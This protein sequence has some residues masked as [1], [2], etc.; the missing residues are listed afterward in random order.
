VLISV[1]FN[2]TKPCGEHHYFLKK[3][4]YTFRFPRLR[5]A[6]HLIVRVA[7]IEKSSGLLPSSFGLRF[8]K[9][10]VGTNISDN[11]NFSLGWTSVLQPTMLQPTMLQPT[12]LQPTVLQ[13]TVFRQTSIKKR[14]HRRDRNIVLGYGRR[15]DRMLRQIA[16][17]GSSRFSLNFCRDWHT[18]HIIGRKCPLLASLLAVQTNAIISEDVWIKIMNFNERH[19]RNLFDAGL[20]TQSYDP[21]IHWVDLLSCYAKRV[22]NYRSDEMNGLYENM[23]DTKA[24]D[25]EDLVLCVFFMRTIFNRM[26]IQNTKLKALQ[27]ASRANVMFFVIQK[28][29]DRKGNYTKAHASILSIPSV[30][31]KRMSRQRKLTH[32]TG[33]EKLTFID[34]TL[35]T[36]PR[37][38]IMVTPSAAQIRW[39][40]LLTPF[41]THGDWAEVRVA[42]PLRKNRF[43]GN[44]HQISTL[45]LGRFVHYNL[46]RGPGPEDFGVP[47]RRLFG[48]QYNFYV[49]RQPPVPNEVFDIAKY[50]ATFKMPAGLKQTNR[51]TYN[52]TAEDLIPQ[53]ERSFKG[54]TLVAAGTLSVEDF[55]VMKDKIVEYAKTHRVVLEKIDIGLRN[56]YFIYMR[57]WEREF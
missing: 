13:P 8:T 11:P 42:S 4:K 6:T 44:V 15:Q 5:H 22:G 47:M 55:V 7:D 43:Y 49:Q 16:S 31:A 10:R 3:E 29:S 21:R 39:R 37:S 9:V 54:W 56:E 57:E 32:M 12:M 1:F 53:D 48:A 18:Q 40:S 52:W 24:G 33:N 51:P 45:E 23:F 38:D 19:I 27:A 30:I 41:G 2:S 34:A 28:I 26:T 35:D 25:C 50:D 36:V 46:F 14:S 20:S 17:M